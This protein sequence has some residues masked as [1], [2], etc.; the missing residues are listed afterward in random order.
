MSHRT[1]NVNRSGHSLSRL[2]LP[3]RKGTHW[4]LSELKFNT[5]LRA[6]SQA[7]SGDG[8]S[9]G[10]SRADVASMDPA[11]S[12]FPQMVHKKRIWDSQ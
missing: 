8:D 10:A 1:E 2:A 5:A 3:Y 7:F 9:Y 12:G 4:E 6:A 11:G